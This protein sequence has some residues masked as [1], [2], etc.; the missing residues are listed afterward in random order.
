MKR[1]WLFVLS[2]ALFSLAGCNIPWQTNNKKWNEVTKQEVKTQT[3]W[4]VSNVKKNTT[5]VDEKL[6]WNWDKFI[7]FVAT[8]CPHC[9]EAVPGLEQFY[10]DYSWE[11]NME[12]NVIDKK[13]FP[14]VKNLPE[15]YKNPKSYQDYTNEQC[16]YIPS[17]V[18]VDKNGKVIDKKC[19]WSLT[20]QQLKDK[21]LTNLQWNDKKNLQ[22]NKTKM[23][24]NKIVKLWDT[25]KVDYVWTFTDGKVFDTSIESVAKK[26]GIYNEARTYEPL[27]FKV[28]AGQM[29]KC[30]DKWVVGMKVGETKDISCQP[31]DA[32]GKCNPK[33]VQKVEKAKLR[34]F[35]KNGYKLEKWTELPTQYGML[36]I[37]NVDWDIVTLDMNNPMCGKVLNFKITV[38]AIQE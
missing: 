29:I 26:A 25:V 33:K 7:W 34:D 10:T 22:I 20:Y 9:Q 32:Y 14:W 19:G 23:T 16:G 30:F 27:G 13:P 11:V 5:V 3:T 35:E 1:Y 8:W 36:K 24:D 15:N 2:I 21:L 37:T 38:K 18:I 4:A 31:E 6:K 17:Y 28:W 12:I